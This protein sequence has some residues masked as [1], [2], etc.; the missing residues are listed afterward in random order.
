MSVAAS[1]LVLA[2]AM[3]SQPTAAP[4]PPKAGQPAT[5]QPTAKEPS[6]TQPRVVMHTSKGD[7]VIELDSAK[8]PKTVEN[9]LAYTRAGH[10]DGT[11]FHRVMPGFV[12]QGGGYT[13]DLRQKPTK[14]PIENEAK[15]GLK[16]VRGSLS[17]ARTSDPNSATSQFFVN[18]VDNKGLDPSPERDPF[19]Y[20]VFGRVVEGMDVVDA[21]AKV[22]TGNKGMFQNVPNEPIVITKAEVVQP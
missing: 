7:I 21:I 8:A 12:I 10:F 15:N 2:L 22:A 1:L 16:N 14:P 18:L 5:S 4:Q 20:A 11:V 9:F 17:M 13:A 6:V 19:G 3:P